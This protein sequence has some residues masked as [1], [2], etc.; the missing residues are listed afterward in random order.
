MLSFFRRVTTSRIGAWVMAAI[1][2]A[3][4]AGFAA[5]D[6]S[7]FG[8]GKIGFGG[9]AV[10]TLAQ[11]GDQEVSEREMADAMQRR[12]QEVRQQNPEADYAT[13]AGEFEPV[14]NLLIDQRSLIA[15]ADKYGFP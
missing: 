4:L 14:L 8:T 6:L 3:I 1:M 15:F 5:A 13:I 2:V 11:V 12:L 9:M 10:T 7:N